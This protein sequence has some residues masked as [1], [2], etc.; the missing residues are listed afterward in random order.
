MKKRTSDTRS[1]SDAYNEH[2]EAGRVS[3]VSSQLA[4]N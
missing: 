4:T 3:L 2:T 1:A